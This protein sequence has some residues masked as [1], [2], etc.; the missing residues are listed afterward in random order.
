MHHAPVA[1]V[2]TQLAY[3]AS[4]PETEETQR[5][6][7]EGPIKEQESGLT[8]VAELHVPG[9][10]VKLLKRRR[11]LVV[12]GGR[13]GRGQGEEDGSGAHFDVC[14]VVDL[15]VCNSRSQLRSGFVSMMG[16][17]LLAGMLLT[18]RLLGSMY[19]TIRK[20]DTEER[21]VDGGTGVPEREKKK[22]E[23]R[24]QKGK[25]RCDCFKI[26]EGEGA[27]AR[28]RER[29]RR[30]LDISTFE[31]NCT[32]TFPAAPSMTLGLAL[33]LAGAGAGPQVA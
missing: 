23:V 21:K 29:V 32:F 30:V 15:N 24:A 13:E 8:S 9:H 10:D 12:R 25:G 18:A 11:L 19:R 26:A 7:G 3:S 2:S 5:K 16:E 14:R 33:A 28:E 31:Y 20:G 1:R 17:S 6:W 4:S 27:R 22:Y